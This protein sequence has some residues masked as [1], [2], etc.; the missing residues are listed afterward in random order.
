MLT[1]VGKASALRNS[2]HRMTHPK[3]IEAALK[4]FDEQFP[5][6]DDHERMSKCAC[7]TEEEHAQHFEWKA[8]L[9]EIKAFL[10]SELTA[11]YEEVRGLIESS[12]P[13]ITGLRVEGDTLWVGIPAAKSGA[14]AK[15]FRILY[16]DVLRR[17]EGSNTEVEKNHSFE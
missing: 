5:L 10:A 7:H 6:P 3:I 15:D 4:R 16:G 1:L 17:L 8:D 11:V 9:D 2:L 12:C 14:E 13:M